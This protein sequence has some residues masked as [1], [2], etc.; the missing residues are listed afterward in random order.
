MHSRIC[1]SAFDYICCLTA[2][3]NPVLMPVRKAVQVKQKQ[4]GGQTLHLS[5][6]VTYERLRKNY[7]REKKISAKRWCL[8]QMLINV[9]ISAGLS[10]EIEFIGLLTTN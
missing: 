10:S 9:Q 7:H 8:E 3:L 1:L 5:M 2:T 4:I 6:V